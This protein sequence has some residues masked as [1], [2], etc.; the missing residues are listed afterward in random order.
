MFSR[1]LVTSVGTLVGIIFASHT[2]QAQISF[3]ELTPGTLEVGSSLNILQSTTP[4][5]LRVQAGTAASVTVSPPQLISGAS[6][7]PANTARIGILKVGT[8]EIR[9]DVGGG[10][11]PLP[12]GQTDLVVDMKIQRPENFQPGTYAYTILLTVIP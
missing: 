9:S 8:V 1:T 12:P 10:S 6:P 11:V 5:T 3:E 4:A 7:D 2:A